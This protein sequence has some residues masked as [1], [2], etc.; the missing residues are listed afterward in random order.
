MLNL[1]QVMDNQID[2]MVKAGVPINKAQKA[3]AKRKEEVDRAAHV[4]NYDRAL[5]A[6]KLLGMPFMAIHSPAD[7]LAEKTVQEHLDV[8]LALEKCAKL[9]DVLTILNKL[10]EYKNTL[11]KP[12]IRV[13]SEESYAGKVFVTMAGGTG[14]GEEVANAYFEAGVGTLIVMHMPDQVI[15]A[16]KKQNIG[17]VIV[18]GHMASDS[19]GINAVIRALEANGLEIFRA[20]GVIPG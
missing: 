9:K 12:I 18:A 5:S 13:G 2:R 1:H 3:L 8:N 11:A 7:L 4:G 20:S 19:I 6:A 17:N 15:E 10:S 16:V 14:G